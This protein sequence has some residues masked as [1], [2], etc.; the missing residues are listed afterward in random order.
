MDS[1]RYSSRK[2]EHDQFWDTFCILPETTG[3]DRAVVADFRRQKNLFDV[4][5]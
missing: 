4:R 3:G 1:F 5:F 2:N